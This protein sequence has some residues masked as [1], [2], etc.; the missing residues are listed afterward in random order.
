MTPTEQSQFNEM[1]LRC[2]EEI[3][4][5]RQRVYHLEMMNPP[6]VQPTAPI[7]FPPWRITCG[8]PT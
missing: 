3:H 1:L 8:G 5:L 7:L 4:A 6:I 2:M